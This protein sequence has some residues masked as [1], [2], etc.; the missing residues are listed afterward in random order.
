MIRKQLET[1]GN[2]Q[3][4]EILYNKIINVMSNNIYTI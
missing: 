2:E 1:K 4:L 3:Q